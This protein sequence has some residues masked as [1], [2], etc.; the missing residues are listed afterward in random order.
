VLPPGLDSYVAAVREL[1]G[2]LSGTTY[3]F[4]PLPPVDAP[5]QPR[6]LARTYWIEMLARAHAASFV[7]L[8]RHLRWLDAIASCED[9]P[10]YLGYCAALRGFLESA[11]DSLDTL[12]HVPLTLATCHAQICLALSGADTAVPVHEELEDGL[13]HFLY[14]RKLPK[15]GGG[16]PASHRNKTV[17]DYLKPLISRGIPLVQECYGDLCDVTHSG[18]LSVTPFFQPGDRTLYRVASSAD[19]DLILSFAEKYGPMFGPLTEHA[20]NPAV[21]T[22]KVLNR[23]SVTHLQSRFVEVFNISH[24][25][26][27]QEI[28]A[29]FETRGAFCDG[30]AAK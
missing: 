17:Q 13:I 11:A 1:C 12:L 22:L 14:A 18:F 23:F 9:A 25:S 2:R 19:A 10:N 15:D 7:A 16:F 4:V 21:L 27:W 26:A 3:D 28:E 29:A 30:P 6:V 8:S 5:L 20:L 24:L